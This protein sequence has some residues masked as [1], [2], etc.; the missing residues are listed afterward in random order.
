MTR[1]KHMVLPISQSVG[2]VSSTQEEYF[3][4]VAK[5]ISDQIEAAALGWELVSVVPSNY[6]PEILLCFFKRKVK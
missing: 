4:I 5:R 1:F 3:A 6:N 2:R